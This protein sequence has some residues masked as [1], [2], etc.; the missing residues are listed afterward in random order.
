MVNVF[1]K[2]C[3]GSLL[4]TAILP[5][6]FLLSDAYDNPTILE[7]CRSLVLGPAW[8]GPMDLRGASGEY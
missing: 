7:F 5:G 6:S 4:I 3:P 8:L 2:F 1:S